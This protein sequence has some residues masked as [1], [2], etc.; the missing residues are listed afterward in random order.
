MNFSFEEAR[1]CQTD[2]G[3]TSQKTMP[4]STPSTKFSP[5]P[6]SDKLIPELWPQFISVV[7]ERLEVGARAYGDKSFEL[8]AGNLAVEIEQELLDVFGWGFIQWCRIQKLKG[9]LDRLERMAEPVE[10][11][12]SY[13]ASK[14]LLDHERSNCNSH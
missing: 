9:K 2:S 7:R 14:A 4:P 1:R 3:G 5:T 10:S 8:S 12:E 6:V 11:D 13:E